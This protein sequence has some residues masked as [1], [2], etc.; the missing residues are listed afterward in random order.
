MFRFYLVALIA[1]LVIYLA[2]QPSGP[3]TKG[4]RQEPVLDL[5]RDL[6]YYFF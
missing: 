6:P 5:A 2:A 4:P 1:M 3:E